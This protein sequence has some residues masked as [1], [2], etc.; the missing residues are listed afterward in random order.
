MRSAT[1][2]QQVF[3]LV[4]KGFNVNARI[5]ESSLPLQ[6]AQNEEV[7][8]ALIDCG[9]DV[10]ISVYGYELDG[11][12]NRNC[13][14]CLLHSLKNVDVIRVVLSQNKLNID[15]MDLYGKTP[16]YVAVR[17]RLPDVIHVLLEHG[18]NPNHALFA[19]SNINVLRILLKFGVDVNLRCPRFGL[20]LFQISMQQLKRCMLRNSKLI[21]VV[22]EFCL[23]LFQNGALTEDVDVFL[24]E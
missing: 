3:D 7:A 13:G 9:A 5:S 10:A 12:I 21:P 1:T 6:L 23:F 22:K 11:R 19:C 16:L 4:K 24:L 18:A 2:S 8:Q 15:S 20:T 14:R 17:K